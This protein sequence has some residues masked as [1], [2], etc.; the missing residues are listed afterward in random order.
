MY[1][2]L[3]SIDILKFILLML[4]WVQFSIDFV[5]FMTYY[6]FQIVVFLDFCYDFYYS[7]KVNSTYAMHPKTTEVVQ[8]K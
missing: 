6:K 1:S 5:F 7:I 4:L 3:G 2:P 8:V